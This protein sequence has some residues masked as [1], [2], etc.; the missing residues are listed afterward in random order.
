MLLAD[1][2]N[3]L[4]LITKN[5][6]KRSLQTVILYKN[7]ILTVR[8]WLCAIQHARV[9]LYNWNALISLESLLAC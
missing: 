4:K 5:R 3:Y 1:E 6:L 9:M 8:D 7:T 2:S